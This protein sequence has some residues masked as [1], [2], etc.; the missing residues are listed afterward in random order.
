[1]L[2]FLL[3]F[4]V[5]F[6][7]LPTLSHAQTPPTSSTE[8]TKARVIRI[9][10]EG[11]KTIGN[12]ENLYQKVRVQLL[13]G[14][15]KGKEISIEY[16]G[17]LII[18]E[19]QKIAPNQTL[20]I[21]KTEQPA[22]QA[23]YSIIDRYRLPSLVW[24][25]VGFI[26]FVTAFTGWK[27]IGA[28]LGM[29]VSLAIIMLFIVPQIITG[30]DPLLI[31]ILGSFMI[32]LTTIYLAHGFS[33]RTTIAVISTFI[34]LI[35]T[36][37]FAIFFVNVANLSGLGSEDAYNLLQGFGGTLNIQGL[38]LGGIIIG[39]LGVLDDTTTTQS[40]TITELAEAN[41]KYTVKDLIRRGMVVGREH[42]TSLVNTLVLAYAG[43]AIGVFIFIYLSLQNSNQP[44]WIIFNSEIIAEE[45]V[46]TLAGSF[47]L[48]LAVPI[49]TVLAAFF[50]KYSV[51][52]K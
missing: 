22:G 1:M 20:I 38:L 6:L 33:K 12:K 36:G 13:E 27:G 39:A 18:T 46:R 17:L 43:A 10:E 4:L 32:M 51:K 7:F 47:G 34:S 26:I 44:W 23:T 50:A 42:I 48:I 21:S 16:G 40:A 24:F 30:R 45:I 35:L 2:R 31:S 9:E 5:I 28:L 14:D 29:L 11:K 19:A 37:I 41:P 15:E 25:F 52:I 8:Y 49:T 3:L